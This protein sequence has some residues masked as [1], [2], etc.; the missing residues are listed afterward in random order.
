MF[1]CCIVYLYEWTQQIIEDDFLWN[2][3]GIDSSGRLAPVRFWCPRDWQVVEVRLQSQE[4]CCLLT[5]SVHTNISI[6]VFNVVTYIFAN[7][8]SMLCSLWKTKAYLLV[9]SLSEASHWV[10]WFAAWSIPRITWGNDI[11]FNIYSAVDFWWLQ[12]NLLV[13]DW[14]QSI[15]TCWIVWKIFAHRL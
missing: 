10:N 2:W 15:T 13:R 11:C 14:L 9:E 8:F 6:F 4:V 1:C 7:T 5:D 12:K 3:F